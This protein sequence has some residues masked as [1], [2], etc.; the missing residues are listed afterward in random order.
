V[1]EVPSRIEAKFVCG[2]WAVAIAPLFAAHGSS[3]PVQ[4]A[5]EPGARLFASHPGMGTGRANTHD[6]QRYVGIRCE[7]ACRLIG[8][9]LPFEKSYRV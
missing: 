2:V 5:Y 6:G 9:L 3:E 1:F 8:S 4:K 7:T